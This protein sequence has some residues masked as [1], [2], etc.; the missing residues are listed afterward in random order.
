MEKSGLAD[1]PPLVCVVSGVPHAQH[2][3]RVCLP[4]ACVSRV[5]D[6]EAHD[7]VGLGARRL[8]VWKTLRFIMRKETRRQQRHM[9]THGPAVRQSDVPWVTMPYTFASE[10]V[11]ETTDDGFEGLDMADDD[12]LGLQTLSLIH[13]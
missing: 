3:T 9:K 6:V 12:F 10:S 5:A 11:N 1:T 13:I 7:D 4:R 2:V 8:D